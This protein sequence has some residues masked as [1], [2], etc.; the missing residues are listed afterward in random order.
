MKRK[1]DLWDQKRLP[2]IKHIISNF[3]FSEKMCNTCYIV[4]PACVKCFS[5]GKFF[6][7]ECDLK[8][9]KSLT[10]HERIVNDAGKICFLLQ[11]EFI[12][13]TKKKI[14]Q[15]IALYIILTYMNYVE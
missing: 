13:S 11:N 5:C 4:T 12:D 15:G 2:V 6:C 7:W 14:T 1:E 9:H 10:L 3:T 8:T